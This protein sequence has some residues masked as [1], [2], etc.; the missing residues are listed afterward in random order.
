MILPITFTASINTL[1]FCQIQLI[2]AIENQKA[3]RFNLGDVSSG[4]FSREIQ[5]D[6]SPVTYDLTFVLPI[7]L[8]P[9]FRAWLA[10]DDF[11]MLKGAPF[12]MPIVTEYGVILRWCNLLMVGQPQQS[13]MTLNTK[14]YTAKVTARKQM[15]SPD[16]LDDITSAAGV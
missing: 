5:T 16:G 3:R 2:Q 1:T 12:N 4:A 7:N 10:Q 14:T 6:D 11:N 13:S 15:N 9:I 8:E